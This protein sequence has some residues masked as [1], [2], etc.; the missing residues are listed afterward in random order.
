M[1]KIYPLH[2]RFHRTSKTIKDFI[3]RGRAE[4]TAQYFEELEK[5]KNDLVREMNELN[6]IMIKTSMELNIVLQLK[7]KKIGLIVDSAES[8]EAIAEIQALPPSVATTN[9]IRRLGLSQKEKH[10]IFILE[11]KEFEDK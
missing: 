7:G 3:A 1:E 9:Y 11:A 5:Q 4:D 2:E 8:V 10:I 6:E